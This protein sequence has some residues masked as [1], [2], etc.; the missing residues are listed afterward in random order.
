MPDSDD[1]LWIRPD[2][3]RSYEAYVAGA[4][5]QRFPG[6]AVR[7]DVHVLGRHSQV[8]RQIDIL[9]DVE[10]L[11]AVECKC[12]TRPVDVKH[13]ESYL[14]MLDDLGVRA[15]ILV[16]TAGYSKAAL[17]RAK[18]DPRNIDLQ[19]VHPDR[20]SEYQHVGLPMLYRE[21]FGISLAPPPFWVADLELNDRTDGPLV[22]MYPLG[23]SLTS[24]LSYAD[25]IYGRI[26]ARP[27]GA[28]T[29]AEVAAPHAADLLLDQPGTRFEVSELQVKD[30][31]GTPRD[32]LLR[33][34]DI[35]STPPECEMALYLDY[36]A[37]IVLLAARS[38]GRDRAAL[39]A[40]LVD[41]ATDSFTLQIVCGGG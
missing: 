28:A 26:L 23:H 30:R 33:C 19:I 12:Y 13:V 3:W 9:V 14:S 35:P 29:L 38:L 21:E 2:D 37:W 1:D 16:T 34:A 31:R 15:G 39:E 10:G 36:D 20:L 24:A 40:M 27:E 5:A 18:N 6:V 8:E 32:G 17:S 25:V 4:M 11:I 22:M 7:R 41:M